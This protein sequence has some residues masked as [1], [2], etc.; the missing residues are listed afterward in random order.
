MLQPVA[1]TPSA[2]NREFINHRMTRQQLGLPPMRRHLA[3]PRNGARRHQIRRVLREK[4]YRRGRVKIEQRFLWRA[5]IRRPLL[6]S[7]HG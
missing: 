5:A 4:E 6:S 7:I 2:R 1:R 3:A